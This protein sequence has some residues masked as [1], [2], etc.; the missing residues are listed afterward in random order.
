M[1]GQAGYQDNV[2]PEGLGTGNVEAAKKILTDAGYR[3]E[4]A[5]LIDPSGKK[6]PTLK[7]VY[8]VGNPIRQQELE[9]LQRQVQPLGVTLDISSTDSFGPTVGGGNFDIVVFGWVGTPFPS[10]TNK[11]IYTTDGGQNFGKYSNPSVDKALTEA[12]SEPDTAKAATLLND[13]D[14]QISRDAYT[15]PL[16]QKPTFL[17]Y[18][19]TYGNIRNNSTSIGPTYN[20]GQWGLR[21]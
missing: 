11:S 2:T 17:A 8:A 6:V 15:L 19:A 3:I 10:S 18:N 4:G 20:I 16:Y 14:R 9:L 21:N 7:A 12:A 1:A 5:A 13:A